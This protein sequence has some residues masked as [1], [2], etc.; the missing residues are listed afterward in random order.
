L[1][2]I[3]PYLSVDDFQAVMGEARR[4]GTY[5][6]GHIPCAVGLEGVLVEGMD[7]IAHAEELVW[8]FAEL[9]RSRQLS[10]QEWG[11][12][13]FQ[14]IRNTILTSNSS[15]AEFE[16][17][18]QSTLDR[19]AN[20][21]QAAGVSVS[22][23]M[24]VA[25]TLG[26]KL[27]QPEAFL[28]RPENRYL[29]PRYLESFR[30]GEEYHQ[31]V[32]RGWEDVF[33]LE[34]DIDIWILASLHEAGV[35]L[36]LGTDAIGGIGIV[37]GFSIHDE[38]RILVENGFTPYEALLTGTVNAA[39]VVEKMTG[40]GNFGAIQIGNR[41]DLILVSGN[42]LKDITTIREPLGVMAVGRWYS[43]EQLSQ[44][45]EIPRH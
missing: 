23:T 7:E 36:V 21:L 38:L 18:N 32:S 5:T 28:S 16:I 15:L 24:D 37:P 4:L 27:F 14:S 2:K 13:L 12:Y 17:E 3:Y 25:E 20:Q 42:P 8:E 19:M 30:R 40:E 29:D 35:Q 33:A 1:L 9:D 34:Y 26:M 43:A 45:I 10:L 44:L 41:A 22:T 6:I 11:P 39:S 31:I